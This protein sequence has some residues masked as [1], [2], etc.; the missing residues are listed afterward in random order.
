MTHHGH[1]QKPPAHSRKP[2]AGSRKP[3]AENQKPSAC[4][5]GETG[6]YSEAAVGALFPEAEAVPKPAFENVF[7]AVAS[8]E[9]DY[10]VIPIEN[11]LFGSVHINYDLLKEHDLEI[12]GETSLRIHHCLLALPGTAIS[13]VRQ[14]HSHPQALGQ[15][16]AWLRDALPGADSI[17]A[18]DTAG[19]ARMVAAMGVQ[20]AAAIASERAAREYGLTILARNI[21]SNPNNYTRFLALARRD[22]PRPAP[23]DAAQHKSTILYSLRQNVPG[24]LFKTLAVFALRDID[25]YKIESRPL[26]GEPGRYLF[27]VDVAGRAGDE[28]LSLACRHLTELVES[29][30]VLGSYPIGTVLD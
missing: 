21:E 24:A 12:I 16:R 3:E 1:G 15:C 18:Y 2:E 19:A 7:E 4:F 29:M 20:D 17:P 14:V 25:L 13:Q 6:A 27:Y 26:I 11:S 9:C 28:P 5:Q 22:A 10:G 8:G 30:N 23:D